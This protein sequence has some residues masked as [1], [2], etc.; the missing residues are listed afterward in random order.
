M[1]T[2]DLPIRLPTVY[3]IDED[4]P[5][6]AAL[7]R[8]LNCNG[9]R[10]L[11]FDSPAQALTYP[12]REL[13]NCVLADVRWAECDALASLRGMRGSRCRIPVVFMSGVADMGLAVRAMR[14]GA[15]DVLCRPVGDG[16]LTA[17]VQAAIDIDRSRCEAEE[18]VASLTGRYRGLTAREREV[19]QA[20]VSGTLTKNI[21][22]DLGLAEITVKIHRA[23]I[24]K[25][26]GARSLAELVR[27]V[28][29]AAPTPA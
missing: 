9:R 10:V 19:A 21:A 7:L 12:H 27:L 2:N 16:D 3:V 11:S 1:K 17:A 29:Q 25:K 26:M 22:M 14:A 20:V 8:R 28:D 13:P 4:G 23:R 15:V 24:M 5:G 18:R 6:R